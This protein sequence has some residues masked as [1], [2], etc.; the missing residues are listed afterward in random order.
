MLK[1]KNLKFIFPSNSNLQS[2]EIIY[3][4]CAIYSDKVNH[5]YFIKRL[6]VN[7]SLRRA[8]NQIATAKLCGEALRI[9]S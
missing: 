8:L 5:L 7:K 4:L 1:H 2:I 6:L 9:G 3:T